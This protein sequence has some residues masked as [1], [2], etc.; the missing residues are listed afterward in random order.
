MR[1]RSSQ[2]PFRQMSEWDHAFMQHPENN[3]LLLMNYVV[4]D[5]TALRKTV[6]ICSHVWARFA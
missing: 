4:D 3:Q 1:F 2:P 5:M 6:H